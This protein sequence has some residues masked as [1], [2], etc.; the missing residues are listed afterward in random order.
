MAQDNT[1]SAEEPLTMKHFE[2]NIRQFVPRPSAQQ[3]R[4]E[5]VKR[6]L[7]AY[8][9]IKSTMSPSTRHE[10]YA[11]IRSGDWVRSARSPSSYSLF[12]SL[13]GRVPT[14]GHGRLYYP[15]LFVCHAIWGTE[16]CVVRLIYEFSAHWGVLFDMDKLTYPKIDDPNKEYLLF[17]GKTPAKSGGGSQVAAPRNSHAMGSA[18]RHDRGSLPSRPAGVAGTVAPPDK[19][20]PKP[21][22]NA[23]ATVQVANPT[24][25]PQNEVG[26]KQEVRRI[27]TGNP[28]RVVQGAVPNVNTKQAHVQQGTA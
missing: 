15:H 24:P 17:L 11:Y 23:Q 26:I 22:Q 25:Q 8:E 28:P 10:L 27:D 1:P 7:K 12:R 3:W 21:V 2:P 9:A 5:C 14:R 4:R 18:L 20:P 13:K 19:Q 6:V 16:D